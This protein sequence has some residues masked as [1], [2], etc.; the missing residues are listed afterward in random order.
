MKESVTNRSRNWFSFLSKGAKD[1]RRTYME[2]LRQ[3]AMRKLVQLYSDH[4]TGKFSLRELAERTWG[5]ENNHGDFLEAMDRAILALRRRTVLCIMSDRKTGKYFR[6][7]RETREETERKFRE[8]LAV[9]AGYSFT[10]SHDVAPHVDRS[11]EVRQKIETA[12]YA[13]RAAQRQKAS[14]YVQ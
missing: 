13:K 9:E 4:P 11:H 14:N 8:L 6:I 5:K 12:I 1:A 10:T 3:E 7:G 2:K